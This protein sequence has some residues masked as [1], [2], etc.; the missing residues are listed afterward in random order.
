MPLHRE[1]KN[2]TVV[3]FYF[4]FSNLCAVIAT[5]FTFTVY[6]FHTI[7][8]SFFIKNSIIFSLQH[9]VLKTM[10]TLGV[11]QDPTGF[12]IPAVKHGNSLSTVIWSISGSQL[13][14]PSSGLS[15]LYLFSHEQCFANCYI[16]YFIP[17]GE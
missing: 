3:Y 17:V 15:V 2:L 8:L 12:P 9:S 16:M 5:H 7:L 10:A 13:V 14:C 11:S 6:K 1:K 4:S